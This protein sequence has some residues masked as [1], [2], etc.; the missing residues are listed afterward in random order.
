[1]KY[2]PYDAGP[3]ARLAHGDVELN[4]TRPDPDR[5]L[6]GHRGVQIGYHSTTGA[7]V[8]SGHDY[9]LARGTITPEQ[10]STAERY[11]TLAERADGAREFAS[12]GAGRL[13]PHRQGSPSEAQVNAASELRSAAAAIGG[14]GAFVVRGIVV[15]GSTLGRLSRIFAEDEKSI[16]GR[17]RAALDRLAEL[18]VK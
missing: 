16:V 2:P 18:W 14:V 11:L 12:D 5:P 10:H 17:L 1:M 13:P 7:R 8:R 6:R 4:T 9:L 3:V 15:E